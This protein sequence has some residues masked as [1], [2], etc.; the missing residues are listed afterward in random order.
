M[1]I[2]IHPH[3]AALGAE[4]SGIDC[5]KPLDGDAIKT[6]KA[7]WDKYLVLILKMPSS[8]IV[9]EYSLE[10]ILEKELETLKYFLKKDL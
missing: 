4:V 5:A 9:Q 1:A 8:Y 2:S 6:I 10:K 7:A 3:D